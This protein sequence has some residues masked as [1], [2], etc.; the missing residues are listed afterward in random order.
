MISFHPQGIIFQFLKVTVLIERPHAIKKKVTLHV[1][2]FACLSAASPALFATLTGRY[3]L[4]AVAVSRSFMMSQRAANPHLF[5]PAGHASVPWERCAASTVFAPFQTN[6]EGPT[7]QNFSVPLGRHCD[8]AW[9]WFVSSLPCQL[10]SSRHI[11]ARLQYEGLR[12][13]FTS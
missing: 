8:I 13:P 12:P 4:N 7:K 3:L 11:S 5:S 2:I 9:F 1:T 6:A 10:P